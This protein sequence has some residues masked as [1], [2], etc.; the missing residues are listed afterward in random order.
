[1]KDNILI[2]HFLDLK[3]KSA[4]ESIVTTSNFLS[5]EEISETMKVSRVNNEYVNTFYYGGYDEAERKI[6]VFVPKFY[7]VKPEELHKFMTENEIEPLC[8]FD[9]S[10]DKFATLSHRDYLGSLMGLGLKRE[11]IGDIIVRE[12]GCTFFAVKS[13]SE[14]IKENLSKAGRGQLTVTQ[15]N[16][17]DIKLPDVRFETVFVSV[18]SLRLD[19]T[20][21]AVFKLSRNDAVNFISQGLVYVNGLQIIKTDYNISPFDKLV[22]RSKGKVIIGEIEGRSKKG[23]LHINVKRYL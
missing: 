11:M 22:L 19:C 23:R 16:T 17:G 6:A 15:C 3:E 8:A 7:C 10:K 4:S 2:S 14:Y 9:V 12:T 20:V 1:M 5:V 18:A 13:V 21:A